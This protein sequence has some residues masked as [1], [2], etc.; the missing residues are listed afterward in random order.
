[1]AI[2]I[3]REEDGPPPLPRVDKKYEVA[4]ATMETNFLPHVLPLGFHDDPLSE[5]PPRT[6]R[7]VGYCA[8]TC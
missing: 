5:S 4:E 6:S 8:E 2:H 1:M 3:L 7:P